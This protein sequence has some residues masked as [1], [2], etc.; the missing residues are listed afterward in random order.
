MAT[1]TVTLS[2]ASTDLTT[3]ALSLSN[4]K[5]LFDAGTSTGMSQ[6]EGVARKFLAGDAAAAVNYTIADASD[7]K[8]TE[9]GAHKI[10]IKNTSTSS[11]DYLVVIVGEDGGSGAYTGQ[12]I[13]RLYGGDFLYMP[14]SADEDGTDS[15]IIV[16]TPSG[17]VNQE[18]E[19]LVIFE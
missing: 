14:W 11:S 19:Y 10:Y 12:E 7:S 9:D 13:G 15:D 2:I 8:F 17:T 4:T 6:V 1:T 5:N 3:D 18:I 16:Q